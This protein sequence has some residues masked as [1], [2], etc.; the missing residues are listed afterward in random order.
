MEAGADW[1]LTRAG[2][3]GPTTVLAVLTDALPISVVVTAGQ[4]TP[5]TFHFATEMLGNVAFGTGGVDA[6]VALDAGAFPMSTGTV[7]GTA[8]MSVD[9]VDGSATF[10]NALHFGGTL[11][12]SY[13]L[14]LTRSGGWVIASDQVCAPVN[15]TTSASS[16]NAALSAI[17]S[18]VSGGTGTICFGDPNLTGA[19]SV[20]LARTGAPTTSTMK[21]DLPSG[22][23]FEVALTGL[24]PEVFDGTTLRLGSLPEPFAPVD[25]TVSEVVSSGASVL[26]DVS[27]APSGTASVT[28]RR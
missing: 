27:S 18:E 17:V 10:N 4:T 13:T 19:F 14:S 16:K 20:H 12:V 15:A 6:G 2:D 11:S 7:T 8:M 9:A 24:A 3:G 21:T 25:V 1:A 26:A 23:T 5:L 28:L 22:G